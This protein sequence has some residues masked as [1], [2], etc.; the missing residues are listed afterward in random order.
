MK[1]NGAGLAFVTGLSLML[2]SAGSD[3]A[4]RAFKSKPTSF[5]RFTPDFSSIHL[6]DRYGNPVPVKEL[7][8]KDRNLVF[9]FFFTQCIT[10]CTTTTFTL[11]GVEPYLPR[12]ATLVLISIDPDNDT[13]AALKEY[14]ALHQLNSPGWKLLTGSRE[15]I[16]RFQRLLASYRGNKMNHNTSI[17]VKQSG[18]TSVTEVE[19]NFSVIPELFQKESELAS[20]K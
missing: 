5:T 19:R 11:K 6:T 18:C 12:D 7:F 2:L 15:D 16:D 13:P 10:I 4:Y 17:F 20:C 9:A 3:G 8:E 1:R 14:A